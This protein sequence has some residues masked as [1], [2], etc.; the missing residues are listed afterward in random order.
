MPQLG[1]RIYVLSVFELTIQRGN[2]QDKSL[3]LCIPQV[4]QELEAH[5]RFAQWLYC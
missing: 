1:I 4:K 3:H 2:L 5:I